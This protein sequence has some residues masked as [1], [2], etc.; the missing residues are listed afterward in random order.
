MTRQRVLF[1]LIGIAVLAV[2][3][4]AVSL[5]RSFIEA[6]QADLRTRGFFWF[7]ILGTRSPCEGSFDIGV[8]VIFQNSR[9]GEFIGGRLCRPLDGTSRWNW[10]PDPAKVPA[11]PK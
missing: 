4:G 6:A 8:S 1:V 5:R 3:I 2:L 11:R 10:S 9:D 7:E